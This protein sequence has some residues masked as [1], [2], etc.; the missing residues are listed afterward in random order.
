MFYMLLESI[1]IYGNIDEN[2][3]ILVY[4][5]TSFV[6]I[7][8]QH[9]LYSENIK[10]E[11]N[12][13]YDSIDKACKAR[14]DLFHL[15]SINNYS[16]ILYLDT[17]ILIKNDIKKIFD[18]VKE[19]VLYV[20]EEGGINISNSYKT[21][22]PYLSHDNWGCLLFEMNNELNNYDDKSAFTSGILLF[23]NCEKIKM[24]FDKTNE[25]IISCPYK[26]GNHD[27]PFIIYNAFKYNLYNNK[28][29]KESCVN[30]DLNVTNDKSI[31]HF[32][33]G[34]GVYDHKLYNMSIF[35]Y[36]LKLHTLYSNIHNV[37][38]NIN[39]INKSYS[40]EDTSITFLENNKMNALGDG[41]YVELNTIFGFHFVL[42]DFGST[43]YTLIFNDD[44][45]EFT[46][47][48]NHNNEINKRKQILI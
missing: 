30:N 9:Y 37:K 15:K 12:D 16:K 31:H 46:S 47:I 3:D 10:F 48:A 14:L 38:N 8:K 32:P 27:Q 18:V 33:G 19:D 43:K 39:I 26:F 17:D 23:N 7:I 21:E 5:S 45:T 41:Q 4:T 40:W 42:T 13:T 34:P 2:I 44:Y 6:E 11:V 1:Y 35:M 36:N 29:L 28:I 20:L 24:L 22:D 25:H